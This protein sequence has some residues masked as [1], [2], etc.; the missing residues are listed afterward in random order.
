MDDGET[1]DSLTMSLSNA[2]QAPASLPKMHSLVQCGTE[3]YWEIESSGENWLRFIKASSGPLFES[4]A[5]NES[6]QESNISTVFASIASTEPR[7]TAS[8][9]SAGKEMIIQLEVCFVIDIGYLL[10]VKAMED[11]NG[12]LYAIRK[13]DYAARSRKLLTHRK[14]HLMRP[15]DKICY[16]QGGDEL[17]MEYKCETVIE[18]S[19]SQNFGRESLSYL[20]N[21]QET[22]APVTQRDARKSHDGMLFTQDPDPEDTYSQPTQVAMASPKADTP[23]QQETENMEVIDDAIMSPASSGDTTIDP[24]EVQENKASPKGAQSLKRAR[25]S[26]I[27]VDLED[28]GEFVLKSM[29]KEPPKS[30]KTLKH[31][32]LNDRE[33]PVRDD[34]KESSRSQTLRR[35]K[36]T[37]KGD[38]IEDSSDLLVSKSLHNHNGLSKVVNSLKHLP[39]LLNDRETPARDDFAESSGSQALKSEKETL[40]DDEIDNSNDLHVSESLHSPELV[41]DRLINA[42]A[43]FAESPGSQALKIEKEKETSKGDKI[44]DSNDP[45]VSE[46]VTNERS[47]AV[48]TLKQSPGLMDDRQTPDRDDVANSSDFQSQKLEQDEETPKSDKIKNSS[49]PLI[50]EVNNEPSKAATTLKHSPELMFDLETPGKDDFAESPGSQAV[51]REKAKESFIG[52]EIVERSDLLVSESVN[53]KASKAVNVVKHSPAV[54]KDRETETSG[55]QA[56]KREKAKETPIGDEIEDSSDSHLPKPLHSGPRKSAQLCKHLPNSLNDRETPVGEV[57]ESPGLFAPTQPADLFSTA[58]NGQVSHPLSP[59]DAQIKKR[60]TRKRAFVVSE[61]VTLLKSK[62]EPVRM[63]RSRTGS[64]VEQPRGGGKN[65]KGP[66]ILVT[67]YEVDSILEEVRLMFPMVHHPLFLISSVLGPS[68]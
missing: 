59:D 37:P 9:D 18:T 10:A 3:K 34:M 32:V 50:W 49:D 13:E 28:D 61:K 11:S 6:E 48:T 47:K 7:A 21:T 29:H 43:D 42:R 62:S 2:E 22:D 41:N 68:L 60:S 52:D 20:D 58:T 8:T 56:A 66:Q 1:Q 4:Q 57:D 33:T 31:S 27:R 12:K 16:I 40:I 65:G 23:S 24:D 35:G 46:S 44:K 45:L 55:S 39:E 17:L 30:A 67:G 25:E 19:N 53:N 5:S 15:G 36:E 38:E 26:P 51:K 14:L 54:M 64:A 63:T